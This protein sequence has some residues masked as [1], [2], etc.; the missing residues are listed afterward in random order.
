M[1]TD[2]DIHKMPPRFVLKSSDNGDLFCCPVCACPHV[3]AREVSVK[4]GR[5]LTEIEHE[6]TYVTATDHGETSTGSVI[7]LQFWCERGHGFHYVLRFEDGVMKI[8]QFWH[9]HRDRDYHN[10]LWRADCP[11]FEI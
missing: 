1:S 7:A 9:P 4:Q 8:H 11:P 5:T 3:H 2:C 10:E 6:T